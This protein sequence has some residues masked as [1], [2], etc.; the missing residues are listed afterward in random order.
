MSIE[1]LSA[2]QIARIL[3]KFPAVCPPKVKHRERSDL[4]TCLRFALRRKKYEPVILAEIER[5][6]GEGA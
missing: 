3:S 6:I 1:K 4:M 2:K 5:E